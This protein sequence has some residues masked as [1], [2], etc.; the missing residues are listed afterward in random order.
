MSN[1]INVQKRAHFFLAFSCICRYLY[2]LGLHDK[3]N[4]PLTAKERAELDAL[5]VE[6]VY[7]QFRKQGFANSLVAKRTPRKQP[8]RRAPTNV[9]LAVGAR[10]GS[11]SGHSSGEDMG[12]DISDNWD[13]ASTDG[14]TSG[15]ETSASKSNTSSDDTD[16]NDNAR[17]PSV[18]TGTLKKRRQTLI[19]DAKGWSNTGTFQTDAQATKYIGVRHKHGSAFWFARVAVRPSSEQPKLP[20]WIRHLREIRSYVC[21]SSLEAARVADR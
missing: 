2:T 1:N 15:G 4:F 13:K 6:G 18:T 5:G 10:N 16:S 21:R 19:N 14:N 11:G 12:D 3:L 9:A 20:S 17:H 8:G 7:K